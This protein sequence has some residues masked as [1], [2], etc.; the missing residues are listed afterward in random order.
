LRKT[1]KRVPD[2]LIQKLQEQYTILSSGGTHIGLVEEED[3]LDH[4]DLE[5]VY[6]EL[7]SIL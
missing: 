4:D 5:D 3:A 1:G 7:I 6:N 2:A